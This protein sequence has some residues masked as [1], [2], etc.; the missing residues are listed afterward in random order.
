MAK[1]SQ[2]KT[3]KGS[4]SV[5]QKAAEIQAAGTARPDAGHPEVAEG[6]RAEAP[7]EGPGHA[8]VAAST[9][10]DGASATG[11]S[12]ATAGKAEQQAAH[13]AGLAKE[14]HGRGHRKAE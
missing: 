10:P 12:A 1:L 3:G 8:K 13:E 5:A 2:N 11:T 6:G 9:A 7:T 4:A 14:Q